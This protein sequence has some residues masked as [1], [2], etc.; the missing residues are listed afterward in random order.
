MSHAEDYTDAFESAI[1]NLANSQT[2]H[3]K[4]VEQTV[5]IGAAQA[6]AVMANAAAMMHLAETIRS[7]ADDRTP[8]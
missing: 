2:P 8:L 1:A 4:L 7:R 5:L 3:I 6:Q